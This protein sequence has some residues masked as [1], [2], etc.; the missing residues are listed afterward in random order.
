MCGRA[1]KNRWRITA[2][3]T[4][5]ALKEMSKEV[6]Q[7]KKLTKNKPIKH[8]LLE[9]ANLNCFRLRNS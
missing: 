1:A 9:N 2:K 6:F 8:I 3:E 7:F 4:T 5:D